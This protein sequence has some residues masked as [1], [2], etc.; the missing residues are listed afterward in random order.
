MP[1]ISS[2]KSNTHTAHSTIPTL[3][4]TDTP[5][6]R[7][8]SMAASANSLPMNMSLTPELIAIT[9]S[10]PSLTEAGSSAASEKPF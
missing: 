1:R 10:S 7:N 2:R 4:I 3:P 6:L 5:T 9:S 8:A